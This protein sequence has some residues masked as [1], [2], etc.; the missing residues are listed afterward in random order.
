[1]KRFLLR[2]LAR[3]PEPLRDLLLGRGEDAGAGLG[4]LFSFG[5]R[6]ASAAITFASHVLLARWLGAFEFGVYTYVWV[7]VN[8]LGLLCTAGLSI[9]AVRFLAEYRQPRDH[10]LARGFLRFGR[11]V[12]LGAGFLMAGIG[13]LLIRAVPFIGSEHYDTAMSIGLLALPAM[14]LID[15]QD[16]VGRARSWIGLAFLPPYIL[17]PLLILLLVAVALATLGERSAVL[18]ASAL[19]ISAWLTAGVQFILQHRRF[20]REL[21]PERPLLKSRHWI[22][23]SLP[24]LIMD[25]FTLLMLNLDVM[26]LE[27]FVTPDRIAVYFAAARTITLIAF[28]HFAVTAVAMPRFATSYAER[29]VARAARQLARFRNWTLWPSLAAAVVLLGGGRLILSMFGP[30]FVEGWPL[31]FALTIGYLARAAAGPAESMLVVSG[32]Q[33]QTAMITGLSAAVNGVLNL[34]LIPHLGLMGAAVATATA[35]VLQAS[36]FALAARRVLQE[37]FDP[38]PQAAGEHA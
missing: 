4:A 25:G 14:A 1:M 29:D 12:S 17:R 11:L 8:L 18:A 26:L 37:G 15:F 24:M 16:G 23:V 35:F 7:W 36:L 9:A 6:V 31:M 2:L 27:I 32:R 34:T 10:G 30:E 22:S 3:L 19:T 28:I 33:N 5:I 20:R 13:I 38:P 21:R